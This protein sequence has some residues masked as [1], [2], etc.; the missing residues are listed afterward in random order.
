MISNQK[1]NK[2]LKTLAKLCGITKVLTFH[3]ARHT[4][5]TTITLAKGISIEVVSKMLGHKS[6]K[7]TQHYARMVNT[8][9]QD[10]M[11]ALK[12]LY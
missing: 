7:Q 4:F 1:T 11:Q 8:R 10:E 12:A 5:A 6:I 9:V 3:I 2:H